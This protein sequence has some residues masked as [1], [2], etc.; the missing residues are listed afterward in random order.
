M[1]RNVRQRA[2]GDYLGRFGLIPAPRPDRP[3][4]AM[5]DLHEQNERE[6]EFVER[7][8]RQQAEAVSLRRQ[9]ERLTELRALVKEF[10]ADTV[11]TI[12]R[13]GDPR[14]ELPPD[15]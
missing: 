10:G 11:K 14:F 8:W 13:R 15:L 4:N 9:E 3:S 6:V 5:A 2:G 12:L 7:W 1:R